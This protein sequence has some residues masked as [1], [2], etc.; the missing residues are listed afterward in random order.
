[1][2]VLARLAGLDA[3]WLKDEFTRFGVGGFKALGGYGAAWVLSAE[4]ARRGLALQA[5]SA[6]LAQGGCRHATETL[7]VT[8]P[9]D[10]NGGCA[11]DWVH[12]ASTV[13]V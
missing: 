11:V 9:T 6:D 2:P 12:N 10:G 8:A 4:H 1:M 7:V 3:I 13:A 5:R